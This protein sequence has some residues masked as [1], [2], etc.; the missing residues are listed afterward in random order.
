ML[1]I[2][3]RNVFPD[4]PNRVHS[5]AGARRMGFQ[6]AVVPG[7]VLYGLVGDRPGDHEIRFVRPTFEGELLSVIWTGSQALISGPD[8]EA[9]AI[10][11]RFPA[12]PEPLF[13]SSFELGPSIVELEPLR[14]VIRPAVFSDAGADAAAMLDAV[15]HFTM[16]YLPLSE[17][18]LHASSRIRSFAAT[19]PACVQCTGRVAVR[20]VKERHQFVRLEVD[21]RSVESGDLVQQVS[22]QIVLDHRFYPAPE[23]SVLS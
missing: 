4:S 15:H 7:V 10:L 9:R 1:T 23:G 13:P 12:S 6:S 3:A 5:D 20:I 22:H 2:R 16:R 11:D 21:L 18:W 19:R 8:G 17:P 14:D